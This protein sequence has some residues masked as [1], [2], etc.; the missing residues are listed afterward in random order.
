MRQNQDE[1]RVQHIHDPQHAADKRT[2]AARLCLRS[3]IQP[4]KEIAIV[5]K[6][7]GAHARFHSGRECRTAR[8]V[9]VVAAGRPERSVVRDRAANIVDLVSCKHAGGQSEGEAR[10]RTGSD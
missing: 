1:Q 2:W 5:V 3:L 9:S 4:A 7:L 6:Q 10:A 8:A